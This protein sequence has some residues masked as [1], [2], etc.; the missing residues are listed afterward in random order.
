MKKSLMVV[1]G[2]SLL[3]A[4][5]FGAVKTYV[6]DPKTVSSAK[7][8]LSIFFEARESLPPL[9]SPVSYE[10]V[11]NQLADGRMDFVAH[12]TWAFPHDAG[13]YYLSDK[14]KLEL[15]LPMRLIAYEDLLSGTVMLV[16]T[17]EGS[18]DVQ[19][20][21][22]R[23]A[24]R[25]TPYDER[26]SLE[27]YLMHELWPRRII[28]TA[29]L[30]PEA[31]AWAE[32]LKAAEAVTLSV[33]PMMMSDAPMMMA[34]SAPEVITEVQLGIETQTNGTLEIQLQWPSGFSD[35]LEIYSATDLIA[36]DW[37]FAHT[38]ISTA[39]LSEHFW[40]DTRTNSATRFYLAGNADFDEDGDGLASA[41]EKY[42]YKTLASLFDTDGDGLGDGMEFNL[43]FNPLVAS[44][45]E[46]LG[47]PD[48]DGFSNLEEQK[49][50]TDP[51]SPDS[52]G[53]T[54]TVAAI[55]YYYDEDDRLSDHFVGAEAAQK[56][57]LSATHNF[58]EEVSAR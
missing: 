12:P 47:D 11:M 14:S 4:L 7:E 38:N 43:G 1:V 3:G 2:I 36:A 44:S 6:V 54:G 16:G 20:L 13:T 57:S 48:S 50:G 15:P 55:R 22:K 34:M 33:S 40:T 10:E 39:G 26:S 21:A 53:S 52:L 49:R 46:T 56:I 27:S 28:W 32:L 29:T 24:S 19:V 41:R 8:L 45:I 30:K 51:S 58:S 31:D 5:A 35:T 18:T 37:K 23:R 42:I 9:P 17:P 25:F